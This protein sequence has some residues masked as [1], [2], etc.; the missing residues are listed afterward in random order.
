MALANE[1]I[2]KRNNYARATKISPY[3][4]NPQYLIKRSNIFFF[5]N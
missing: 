5:Y 3:S 2:N 4:Y 1:G